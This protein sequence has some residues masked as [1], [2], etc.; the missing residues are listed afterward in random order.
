MHELNVYIY[1]YNFKLQPVE[2]KKLQCSEYVVELKW[3]EVNDIKN[4]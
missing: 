4:P 1:T 2:D 3:G